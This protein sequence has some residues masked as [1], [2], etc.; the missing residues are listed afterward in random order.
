MLLH[1]PAKINIGLHICGRRPNGYHLLQTLFVAVP[2]LTDD[3]RL[4]LLPPGQPSQLTLT[5]LPLPGTPNPEHNLA[6]RAYLA[7]QTAVGQPL[8]PVHI[9]LHKRIP[10][11]AGLGGG[12]GNAA[13]V[14]C[15]LCQMLGLD[16]PRTQLHQLAL[17]LGAD[18]PFFIEAF[19]NGPPM[20]AEG[21]GEELTPYTQPLPFREIR[22]YLCG[23][24]S[25]TAAAY[26][27][28]SPQHWTGPTPHLRH[29]LAQPIDTWGQN[30]HNDFEAGVFARL[31]AI[32]QAKAQALAQGACYAAMSGSG[33]AVF[34]LFD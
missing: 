14:L 18:V 30:I 1:S 17:T 22:L 6:Y 8:P 5:G 25:D 26:R 28:L 13:Y 3:I 2:S 19:Y 29:R 31:P 33:S 12:S 4:T 10:A 11:G 27:S 34:G 21:I 16:M 32:A 23:E 20:L 24:H 15:G 7:L 9:Q